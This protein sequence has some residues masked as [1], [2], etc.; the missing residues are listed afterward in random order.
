MVAFVT[1]E[2]L[3]VHDNL[4]N[5]SCIFI[6]SEAA[7]L[8]LNICTGYKFVKPKIMCN[9]IFIEQVG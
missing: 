2:L 8:L 5:L 4:I 1:C 9:K 6:G 3:F 7:S